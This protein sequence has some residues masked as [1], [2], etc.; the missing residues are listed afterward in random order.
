MHILS[1]SL[2]LP[3]FLSVCLSPLSLLLSPSLPPSLPLSSLPHLSFSLSLHP[4][5]SLK[6][7][8]NAKGPLSLSRSAHLL[9]R[10]VTG[11]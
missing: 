5:L 1:S 4:S 9:R 3:S 11:P 8:S 7:R 2:P 10:P 6:Y